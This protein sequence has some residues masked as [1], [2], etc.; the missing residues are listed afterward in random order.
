MYICT[1]LIDCLMYML[2]IYLNNSRFQAA[3][4]AIFCRLEK[5]FRFHFSADRKTNDPA[6][7]EWY[8][9]QVLYFI[10]YKH[11]LIVLVPNFSLFMC[12]VQLSA[13]LL[14]SAQFFTSVLQDVDGRQVIFMVWLWE[15]VTRR[16]VRY[17]VF[18]YV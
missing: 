8:F 18:E 17:A 6:H 4:D 9:A 7:P 13:W 15:N 14:H 10:L 16:V 5:R 12:I 11:I 3:A 1:N 2:K